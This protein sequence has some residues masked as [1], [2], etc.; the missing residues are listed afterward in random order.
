MSVSQI[1]VRGQSEHSPP[2]SHMS[3]NNFRDHYQ[4]HRN[5]RQNNICLIISG[6]IVMPFV[7]KKNKN[8]NSKAG[9]KKGKVS[10]NLV[11]NP[12]LALPIL[13]LVRVKGYGETLAYGKKGDFFK[14]VEKTLFAPGS[15]FQG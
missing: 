9:S 7:S 15:V 6:A 12:Q 11:K 2:P 5:R 4:Q 1:W 13:E 14:T 8:A 3:G 10:I